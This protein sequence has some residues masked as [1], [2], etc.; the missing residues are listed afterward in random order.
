MRRFLDNLRFSP[1]GRATLVA[2]GA[3]RGHAA[4]LAWL[5]SDRGYGRDLGLDVTI[6]SWESAKLAADA[7]SKGDVGIAMRAAFV[8]VNKGFNEAALRITGSIAT[9]R[10]MELVARRNPGIRSPDDLIGVHAVDSA[11]QICRDYDERH[12]GGR[13]LDS[14]RGQGR[15]FRFTVQRSDR[16]KEATDDASRC[17]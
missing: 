17:G 15:A 6:E 7:L 5:D 8:A 16:T 4:A 1:Q 11:A 2:V 9:A 13:R 14:A 3:D 12:G 10:N